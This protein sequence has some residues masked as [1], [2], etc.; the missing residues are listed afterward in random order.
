MTIHIGSD[1]IST[2]VV[3]F[4]IG[5]AAR[6]LYPGRDPMGFIFTTLLGIGGAVVAGY[7]GQALHWYRIGQP[8]GLIASV[9]GAILIL[10]LVNTVARR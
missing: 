7:I 10:L 5:L 6:F 4:L 9:L 1:I 8:A 2:I 3:C